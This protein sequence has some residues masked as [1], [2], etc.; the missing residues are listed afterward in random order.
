VAFVIGD[1]SAK[2]C[3]RLWNK[4]PDEYKQRQSF[5][6]FWKSYRPLFEADPTHEQVEKG[7]GELSHVE[8]FFGL[9]RQRLARYVRET[10]SASW[11]VRMHHLVTKLF[12]D[13][14]NRHI[15]LSI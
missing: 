6:D 2:T 11:S 3:A 14:Y 7:S 9:I 4:I 12:V 13:Y 15:A 5:S 8:R 1:R 10:R